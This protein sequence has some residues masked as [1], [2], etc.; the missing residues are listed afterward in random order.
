MR[1]WKGIKI[2]FLFI[3]FALITI[4]MVFAIMFEKTSRSDITVET[5]CETYRL[6]LE[7]IDIGQVSKHQGFL[8]RPYYQIH[9]LLE[10]HTQITLN[11]D[12]DLG[13]LEDETVS[14]T[15]EI[16]ISTGN[17]LL[18]RIRLG[19]DEYVTYFHY[20]NEVAEFNGSITKQE[21]HESSFTEDNLQE[22]SQ[23]LER[24]FI[25]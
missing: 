15:A 10:D 22:I 13:N 16:S 3:L 12:S 2:F 9:L 7:D 11:I 6:G 17:V 24:I 23:M 19:I 5:L 1:I 25:G 20:E 8:K 14:D 18:T 4:A 21:D